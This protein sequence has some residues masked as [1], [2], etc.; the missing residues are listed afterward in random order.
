MK[1][2]KENGWKM[3]SSDH[4]VC[5]GPPLICAYCKVGAV[6]FCNSKVL[7]LALVLVLL[8]LRSL[9]SVSQ[10]YWTLVSG[11]LTILSSVQ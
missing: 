10:L 9:R 3:S 2:E 7:F 6:L 8:S 4:R 5:A 1:R 11:K